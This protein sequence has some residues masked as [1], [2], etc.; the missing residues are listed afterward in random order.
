MKAV[1]S[2]DARAFWVVAPGRG[3]I[4]PTPLP[5]AAADDVTV[6]SLFS[7]VSRGSES[8]V[9]T[10]RV[11]ESER[12]RMRGPF[13]DGEFPGP[14]KYGYSSVGVVEDGP[15]G[16]R[17]RRVFVLHPHQTRFVV[18]AN[19]V[20][21]LPDDVPSERAIL[22]ANLETAINGLWDAT[23]R[24]GDRI[25]IIGAGVVGCLAAWL[26]GRIPGC[27]VRLIDIAGDRARIA[28]ALGV[29]FTSADVVP[30]D[31][32]LVIH[33]SGTA[34]GLRLALSAA[35]QDATIVDLSWYGDQD[36]CL[37]LGQ[38]FHPRRLSVK[39]S[40]VGRVPSS[41]APRWD[42]RRR[43]AMAISLLSNQVLDVLISGEND[44][45]DLPTVMPRLAS[46]AGVAL[47][48][49]IRYSTPT[50]VSRHV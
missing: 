22:A 11:P 36:V 4:R 32:D 46:S 42:T 19:A 26:A 33:T 18:P 31:H 29:A 41:Q 50:G 20:F 2:N 25:A 49:R 44:F 28:S 7:G 21:V 13:Q 17:G 43:M 5:S 47:C 1:H 37:P 12:Q 45:E 6:R 9:F 48:H 16:L 23:P 24:I 38:S 10:G 8:I 14:V 27:A 40:Q 3:E 39:S 15:D 35:A 34:S 30:D